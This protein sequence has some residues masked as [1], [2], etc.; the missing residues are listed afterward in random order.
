M[1]KQV[2]LKLFTAARSGNLQI[3][4]DI[5]RDAAA[6][7]YDAKTPEGNTVLHFAARFGHKPLVGELIT[8]CP[9]LVHQSNFKGETLLHVAA[10]AGRDDVV[11]L[12]IDSKTDKPGLCIGWIRDNSGNSPLHGAVRNGHSKDLVPCVPILFKDEQIILWRGKR[13]QE[14]NSDIS[15]ATMKSQDT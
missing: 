7:V 14:L 6:T 15:D 11:G 8:G 1:E 13:D 12:L 3:L 10:K 4:Q 2:N 9:S 5:I